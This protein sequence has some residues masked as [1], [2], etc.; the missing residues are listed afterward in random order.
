MR[1]A[2]GAGAAVPALRVPLPQ[3]QP[4]Q[5][6][7]QQRAGCGR[8][9]P[10]ALGSAAPG[11]EPGAARHPLRGS[12]LSLTGRDVKSGSRSVDCLC[13][14]VGAAGRSGPGVQLSPRPLPPPLRPPAWSRDGGGHLASSA[15]LPRVGVSGAFAPSLRSLLLA[16]VSRA[17]CVEDAREECLESY[18]ALNGGILN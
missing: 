7:G 10:A 15:D 1:T 12:G 4:Q 9:L 11:C 14:K 18:S 6:E 17:V 5:R 3:M 8:S 13:K 2:A 16:A